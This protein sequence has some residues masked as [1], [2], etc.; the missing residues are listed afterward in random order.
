MLASASLC[1]ALILRLSAAGVKVGLHEGAS[2]LI[3]LVSYSFYK[4]C[5]SLA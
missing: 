4:R 2:G 3:L 5:I 1:V